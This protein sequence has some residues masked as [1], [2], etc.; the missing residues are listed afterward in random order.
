MS[1]MYDTCCYF[2]SFPYT[3]LVNIH[4]NFIF[5]VEKFQLFSINK[6][7][8]DFKY[9]YTCINIPVKYAGIGV[10]VMEQWLMNPTRISGFRFN[11][12]PCSV[13]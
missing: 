5:E 8:S 3:L 6:E 11:P 12:C 1:I 7:N 2:L 13:S 9:I 10:P 4:F